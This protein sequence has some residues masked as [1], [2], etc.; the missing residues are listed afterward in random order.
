MNHYTNNN[1]RKVYHDP[2]TDRFAVVV[3]LRPRSLLDLFEACCHRPSVGS[4][5]GIDKTKNRCVRSRDQELTS[6]GEFKHQQSMGGVALEVPKAAVDNSKGPLLGSLLL[7]QLLGRPSHSVGAAEHGNQS[8]QSNTFFIRRKLLRRRHLHKIQ[9][10][11][12][13]RATTAASASVQIQHP[14]P[15]YA[16]SSYQPAFYRGMPQYHHFM[17]VPQITIQADCMRMPC[18]SPV[19]ISNKRRKIGVVEAI[20]VSV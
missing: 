17:E 9:K 19:Q 14:R 6:S 5:V 16:H 13:E 12:E 1:L 10:E 15:I 8:D 2:R 18:I 3:P 4:E 7:D 20:P 11:R